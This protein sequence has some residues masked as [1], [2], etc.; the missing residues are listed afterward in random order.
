MNVKW[1][2]TFDQFVGISIEGTVGPLE[3]HDRAPGWTITAHDQIGDLA[4]LEHLVG[5]SEPLVVGG[6]HVVGPPGSS[7]SF[8]ANPSR[9]QVIV[10]FRLSALRQSRNRP[11]VHLANVGLDNELFTQNDGAYSPA[12][13]TH[14]HRIRAERNLKLRQLGSRG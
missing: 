3:H 2:I 8:Y 1:L 11:T 14:R 12:G 13:T 4:H 9:R 5:F 7:V 10:V 6:S